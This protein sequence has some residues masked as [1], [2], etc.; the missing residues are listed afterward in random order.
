MGRYTRAGFLGKSAKLAGAAT[1]GG[2][3]LLQAACGGGG[4]SSTTSSGSSSSKAAALTGTLTVWMHQGPNFQKVYKQIVTDFEALHPGVKI[5]SLYIPYAQFENKALIAFTGGSPP[6]VIKL[7]G[8]DIANY[9]SKNLIA[10]ID[11]K[12]LGYASPDEL[13]TAYAPGA[14]ES[15][16][17]KGT[18]YGLPIDYN[19]IFLFYRRDHFTAAGLDP[20]KPPTTWE[21]VAEYA[22]KLTKRDGGNLKRA[23]WAYWYNLPIWDFLNFLPLPAGLGGGLVDPSNKG[24]LSNPAG[25]QALTWFSDLSNKLKVASPKFTNPNFNYGQIADGSASMTVSGNFAISFIESLSKPKITLGKE[26]DVAPMPQWANATKQ[27]TSGYSWAWLVSRRSKNQ[28]LAWEFLRF[29][30]SAKNASSILSVSNLIIPAKDWQSDA[31]A[32]KSKGAQ[33]VSTE[34]AY[35]D[36]GPSLPQWSQMSQQLSNNLVALA[37]GQKSPQQAAKDFDNAMQR[38]G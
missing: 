4:K 14:L 35:T 32:S 16:S 33:I 10:P 28:A 1:L 19:S 6:D 7:G 27:V 21:Q 20:D 17:Y 29:V 31:V 36:Y 3:A 23:G 26:F 8:W 2:G 24:I 13:K 30:E 25:I 22:Q 5:N 37:N 34:L 11:P 9:A 12:A 18:T 38:L 15:V